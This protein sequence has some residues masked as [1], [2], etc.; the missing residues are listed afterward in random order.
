MDV[1]SGVGGGM[2][3]LFVR[4][5]SDESSKGLLSPGPLRRP[6]TLHLVTNLQQR[7]KELQYHVP[8][9]L[10]DASRRHMSSDLCAEMDGGFQKSICDS[11]LLYGGTEIHV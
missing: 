9:Y 10:P 3:P 1:V 7:N 4:W 11:L 6:P 2:E 8:T 5:S